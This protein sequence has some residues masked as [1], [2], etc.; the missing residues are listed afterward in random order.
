MDREVGS[1][2]RLNFD[3]AS[4]IFLI[5]S[6]KKLVK[7]STALSYV[8]DSLGWVSGGRRKPGFG[9]KTICVARLHR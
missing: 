9:E 6:E 2:L 8:R 3:I 5:V 1:R 7:D 4:W